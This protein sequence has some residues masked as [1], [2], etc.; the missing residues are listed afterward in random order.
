MSEYYEYDIAVSSYLLELETGEAT[1]ETRQALSKVVDNLWRAMV[2]TNEVILAALRKVSCGELT[3]EQGVELS[4]SEYEALG[5]G[6]Y[7]DF[8]YLA[9]A[10]AIVLGKEQF[11]A[12]KSPQK[13][14][15]IG[16]VF[17]RN[18]DCPVEQVKN[19]IDLF[20]LRL[21]TSTGTVTTDLDFTK[22]LMGVI[23]QLDDREKEDAVAPNILPSRI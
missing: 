5:F 1:Q 10:V 3:V 23:N 21:L 18:K 8:D 20:C 15:K 16:D 19:G 4:R 11:L 6:Q 14:D 7:L 12:K 13:V 17:R 2:V 9:L 22:Q